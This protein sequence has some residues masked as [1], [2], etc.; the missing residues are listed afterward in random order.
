VDGKATPLETTP[1]D[2]VDDVLETVRQANNDDEKAI[3]GLIC[4][5][6]DAFG[7]ALPGTLARPAGDFKRI[8]VETGRMTDLVFDALNSALG[9]LDE[10]DETRARTVDFFGEGK[11]AD[12]MKL[13]S[14]CVKQW[15]QIN[16]AVSRCMALI[17]AD[18]SLTK[19]D[20]RDITESFEAV[21]DAMSRTKTAIQSQDFVSLADILEYEIPEVFTRWRSVVESLTTCLK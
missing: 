6:V 16:V 13:L 11:H 4:D 18:E 10:A 8:D 3:V 21:R 9:A 7:D 17:P 5:G 14:E 20:Q 15:T 1:N 12:A 2:S 19:G